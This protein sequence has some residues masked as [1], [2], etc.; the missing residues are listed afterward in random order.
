MIAWRVLFL[1]ILDQLNEIDG[2][3][4]VNLDID[5][6][7]TSEEQKKLNYKKTIK[8]EPTLSAEINNELN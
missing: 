3:T 7:K 4:D 2:E 8:K 5:A 1:E 6:E